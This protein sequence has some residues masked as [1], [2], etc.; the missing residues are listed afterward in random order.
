MEANSMILGRIGYE[1]STCSRASEIIFKK[2][3]QTMGEKNSI[4]ATRYGFEINLYLKENDKTK[5]FDIQAIVSQFLRQTNNPMLDDILESGSRG[6][7]QKD[8]DNIKKEVDERC[9]GKSQTLRAVLSIADLFKFYLANPDSKYKSVIISTVIDYGRGDNMAHQCGI[10]ALGEPHN[11]FL[12]YEPYGMYEKYSF[13]YDYC[14]TQFL[15]IFQIVDPFHKYTCET[16]HG[17][18]GA[19]KGIQSFM[20]EYGAA[21]KEDFLKKYEIIKKK[22]VKSGLVPSG[23]WKYEGDDTDKTFSLCT[24]MNY[25][26]YIPEI[27]KESSE[28]YAEYSAKTCVSIFLVEVFKILIIIEKN[29]TKEYLSQEIKKWYS[30]FEDKS[31]SVLMSKLEH[32]FSFLYGSAKKE[33]Y[34]LFSDINKN[35]YEICSILTS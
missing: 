6:L 13:K 15:S 32:I 8:K 29:N 23:K 18:I 1:L 26:S 27:L 33:I 22:A 31:P 9:D 5:K 3:I 30:N 7:S 2:I 11:V 25:T 21:H 19:K 17:Y 24:L 28:L 34:D 10:I 4:A 20:L 35:S 16:Y 14:V 12:F